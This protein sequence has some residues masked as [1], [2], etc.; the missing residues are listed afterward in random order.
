VTEGHTHRTG[1]PDA[2]KDQKRDAEARPASVTKDAFGIIHAASCRSA[3]NF[4]RE[5]AAN[6]AVISGTPPLEKEL[7]ETARWFY[8]FL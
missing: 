7:K 4:V 2:E 5:E 6:R 3:E 8:S 1:Q